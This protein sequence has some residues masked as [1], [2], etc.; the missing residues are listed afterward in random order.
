MIYVENADELRT[1]LAN[2]RRTRH[3]SAKSMHRWLD[4]LIADTEEKLRDVSRAIGT[5]LAG[6]GAATT[7]APESA[8][9]NPTHLATIRS[10]YPYDEHAS[11]QLC[12]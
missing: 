2:Y 9:A 3:T 4:A 11:R 7:S 12:G 10:P 1:K 5:P 8:S 6:A